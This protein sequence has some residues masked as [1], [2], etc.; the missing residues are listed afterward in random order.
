MPAAVVFRRV[1]YEIGGRKILEGLDL[2]IE[3]GETLV[4]L[5]RSGCGKTTALRMVN[6]TLM[7]TTGEVFVEGTSTAQWDPIRLR[8]RTGYVIQ[9]AGLFPHYTVARNVGLVPR[10]EGREEAGIATCVEEQLRRVGLDPV[11]FSARYPRQLS[12]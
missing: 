8:R 9:D 12:G 10:L 4:L 11:E 1:S 2:E 5:G 6:A 3:A 7:P